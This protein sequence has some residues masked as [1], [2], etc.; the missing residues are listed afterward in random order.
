MLVPSS[1]HI[2]VSI[3]LKG[4]AYLGPLILVLNSVLSDLVLPLQ[5]LC[6]V[7]AVM[8]ALSS[9]SLDLSSLISDSAY[10]GLSLSLRSTCQPS[11]HLSICKFSSLDLSLP[12]LG[13]SHTGSSTFLRG[14]SCT[15]V[16]LFVSCTHLGS[17]SP[18]Q[19]VL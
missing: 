6:E 9:V 5:S 2:E 4:C 12:V 15:D 11:F 3:L 14:V 8:P 10:L 18:L 16:V 19:S 17:L 13:I 7:D 1:S